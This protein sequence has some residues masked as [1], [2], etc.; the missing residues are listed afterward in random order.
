MRA[1]H[2]GR[3]GPAPDDARTG[4]EPSLASDATGRRRRGEAVAEPAPR[5]DV[6]DRQL[7]FAMS[8][9]SQGFAV[10]GADHRL[11]V[12]NDA[13]R[14]LYALPPEM[15]RAGTLFWDI[16]DHGDAHDR[17]PLPEDGDRYARIRAII[18]AGQPWRGVYKSRTGRVVT[19]LHEPLPDGGW[20]SLQEDVTEQRLRERGELKRLRDLEAQTMRF[21]AAINNMSQGLSM[22]DADRCL[23]ACNTSFMRL[24]LL[25]AELAQPGTP[26]FD[27]LRHRERLDLLERG[28]NAEMTLGR[29]EQALATQSAFKSVVTMSTGQVVMI[30]HQPLADGGWLSTHEDISEQHQTAEIMRFMARHDGLTGLANRPTFLE[31][32]AD[33]E[34]G[35]ATGDRMAVMCIDIDR[36]K[37]INDAFGHTIGD[38]VLAA[39]GDRMRTEFEGCGIAARL[40]GDDFAA[41]VGPLAQGVDPLRARPIADRDPAP[42][43]SRRGHHRLLRSLDRRR[44]RTPARQRRQYAAALRRTRP[45]PLE[46]ESA[47][48]LLPVRARHGRGAPP[49]PGASN[50]GCAPPSPKT[51]SASTSSRWSRLDS[52]RIACCEALLR[53]KAPGLGAVS[54]AEFV[55]IAEETDLIREI[56]SWA[57]ESACR[58]A[59]SW[60]EPIRVAVNVSPVQFRGDGLVDEVTRAL[61]VSGLDPSRLELEITE[62]LFLADDAHNLE[63]LHRLR[64]LGV[65]FALDDFGTGYSSLA[66]LLRFPFDKVKIDRSIVSNVADTPKAGAMVGAIVD[67]CRGLS[68]LTV[69]EGIERRRSARHRPLARLHRGAGLYLQPGPAARRLARGAAPPALPL[70]FPRSGRALGLNPF[71]RDEAVVATATVR[72]SASVRRRRSPQRG[73]SAPT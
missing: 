50:A 39:I 26:F 48:R 52:G 10:F 73:V 72:A 15:S 13:F 46:I 37:D 61:A 66:Y 25:P 1:K 5:D 63:V 65:R 55:P 58:E 59:S 12:C 70:Q 43:D 23:V 35:I 51:A 64:Q 11:I 33:A 42:A 14:Q 9:M 60:P 20:V 36:F 21:N 41:L 68:M 69:A 30:N 7:S 29:V 2:D 62:S 27:I 4:I 17:V 19:T 45:Q 56:G 71:R 28:E 22:F 24:Y 40:G 3:S 47:R 18:D 57:L 44:P 31:T 6:V 16:L 32:L 49:P 8:Q 67:L 54:P 53:W 34:R 38:A